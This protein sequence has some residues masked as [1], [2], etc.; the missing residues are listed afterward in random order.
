MEAE[1]C[2]E[3][4]YIRGK[5]GITITG[6]YGPKGVVAL[7][8]TIEDLP[9]ISIGDY[10][11]AAEKKEPESEVYLTRQAPYIEERS[12]LGGEDITELYLSDGIRQVGRYAF[13][14]C[15]ALFRL[16]MGN[17]LL[18]IGGGAFSGCRSLRE[19]EIHFKGNAKSALHSIVG[20]E[21]YEICARLYYEDGVAEVLFPEHYEEAEENTPARILYTVHHGAGGY[22]RQCFYERE[23]D[24]KKYDELL[25]YAVA[26]ESAATVAALALARLKFPYKLSS[27]GKESYQDFLRREIV[28]V[29]GYVTRFE[30]V[31]GIRYLGE[32]GLWTKEAL[33]SGIDLATEEKRTGI[34][35]VLMEERRKAGFTAKKTFRL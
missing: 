4:H 9:V 6:C 35:S 20:E 16:G 3:I 12:R 21:R 32:H 25:P 22:Y 18:D 26:E 7:P 28:D 33:E 19:V 23:L 11:F 24:F 5:E 1:I 14:R 31:E 10:A 8:D 30:D 13:Y 34:L 2:P 29:A 27:E 15:S 17:A